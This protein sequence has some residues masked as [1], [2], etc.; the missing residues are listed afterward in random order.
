MSCIFSQKKNNVHN[1]F[2]KHAHDKLFD[3]L[4]AVIEKSG[5]CEIATQSGRGEH[6]TAAVGAYDVLPC[7]GR[8]RHNKTELEA[9]LCIQP[10]AQI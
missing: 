7:I 9:P 6:V 2:V 8:V 4:I 10:M 5:Y 3:H 1:S